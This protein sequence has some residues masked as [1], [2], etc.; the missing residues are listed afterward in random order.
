MPSSAASPVLRAS[1]ADGD[2]PS[3]RSS[4]PSEIP[5]TESFPVPP[6][7]IITDPAENKRRVLEMLAQGERD[8]A[9]GRVRDA[10]DVFREA[11]EKI[12]RAMAARTTR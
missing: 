2:S 8:I 7:W 10:E 5:E 9:A 12:A 3:G 1:P 6:E 11:E 4:V